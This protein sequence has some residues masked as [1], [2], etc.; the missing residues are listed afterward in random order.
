MTLRILVSLCL[1][2]VCFFG[3]NH[4]KG[5][6]SKDIHTASIIGSQESKSTQI[7]HFD[8]DRNGKRLVRKF[9]T[10][11]DSNPNKL[12]IAIINFIQKT[13]FRGNY[14]QLNYDYSDDKSDVI[15]FYFTGNYD[16]ERIDDEEI[17]KK[18]LELTITNYTKNEN[19]KFVFN[20]N[21][22]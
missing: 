8:Y 18:A 13:N 5:Y 22:F 15:T 1:F 7:V 11:N 14:Q 19:I 3:C 20:D 12:E 4:P 16:F 2:N 10:V 6:E 21:K 9:E 17:F